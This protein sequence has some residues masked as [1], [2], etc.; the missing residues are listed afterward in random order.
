M[1]E[2]CECESASG[3]NLLKELE[4]D[5]IVSVEIVDGGDK[6]CRGIKIKLKSGKLFHMRSEIDI[7]SWGILPRIDYGIGGWLRMDPNIVLSFDKLQE[8]KSEPISEEE[9]DK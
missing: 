8:E 2:Q 4:G 3:Y 1:E 9:E 7:N 5:E 6:Y